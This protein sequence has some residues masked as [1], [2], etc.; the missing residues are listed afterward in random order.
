M[1]RAARLSGT[2]ADE[3]F[4]EIL[5]HGQNSEVGLFVKKRQFIWSIFIMNEVIVQL[6][7]SSNPSA[8]VC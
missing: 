8:A 3:E 7:Q 6:S 4:E 2:E 5:E 1:A